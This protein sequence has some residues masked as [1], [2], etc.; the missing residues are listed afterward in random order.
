MIRWIATN[1]DGCYNATV[2]SI[3]LTQKTGEEIEGKHGVRVKYVVADFSEQG[4]ALYDRI[5][6]EI[7]LF[8]LG[9]R[10]EA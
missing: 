5:K 8:A 9:K 10:L 3:T 1:A 7:G 4:M 2:V 6:E